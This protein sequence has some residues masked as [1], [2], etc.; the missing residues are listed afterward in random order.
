MTLEESIRLFS[1]R[2]AKARDVFRLS[3]V[4]KAT[5]RV[6]CEKYHYLGKKDFLGY[7]CFGLFIGDVVCG[8]ASYATPAGVSTL[9]GWFG[10]DNGCKDI[11]ELT[12]LCMLPTLNGTNATSYLLANSMKEL[13][14]RYGVR[15]II[16]LADASRHVGSI[17]QVCNFKYYGL[18][19]A[20]TDFYSVDGSKNKWGTNKSR[21]GVWLPRTRKHR[22][23]FIFDDDL[24]CLYPEAD[25]PPCQSSEH[26][27]SSCDACH[28]KGYVHD[29]RYDVFYT[30]PKCA[31]GLAELS[32]R[33]ITE[34]D[35]L[36]TN[37][38]VEYAKGI[39]SKKDDAQ[40]EQY[41]LWD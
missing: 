2:K 22:Y 31:G 20:K 41:S 6:F 23:A 39:V 10:V 26:E 30:C 18:T 16:T 32:E 21:S 9:K 17:Y 1:Q 15:A 4:S 36:S 24:K 5:C 27:T 8:V 19:D 12:R 34:M 35:A 14:R 25:R 3:E 38:A 28:G 37:D 13:H 40:G 11:L 7:K 33:D 29:D